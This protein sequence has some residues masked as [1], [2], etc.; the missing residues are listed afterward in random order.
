MPRKR[1]AEKTKPTASKGKAKRAF[2]VK[3][4]VKYPA[5]M[6]GADLRTK[7]KR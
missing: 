1:T 5:I 4:G 6:V 7:P 3:G 2:V